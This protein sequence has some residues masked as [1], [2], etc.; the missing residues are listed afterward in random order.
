MRASPDD[1]VARRVV[2]RAGTQSVEATVI[3]EDASIAIPDKVEPSSGMDKAVVDEEKAPMG[4]VSVRAVAS[5]RDV[6][7]LP[8][9]AAPPEDSADRSN[10]L[11]VDPTTGN[12]VGTYV[13][14]LRA[15]H[16]DGDGFG[17][18]VSGLGDGVT[19]G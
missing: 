10:G 3:S 16:G 1:M 12:L 14:S 11:T 5:P 4:T 7:V 8:R 18:P 9:T 2:V 19:C 13:P 15:A 6:V 17:V